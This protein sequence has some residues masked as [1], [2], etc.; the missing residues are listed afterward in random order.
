MSQKTGPFHLGRSGFF[1]ACGACR[2]RLADWRIRT[3]VLCP[4]LFEMQRLSLWSTCLDESLAVVGP[5]A[6]PARCPS[7]CQC[8]PSACRPIGPSILIHCR[9]LVALGGSLIPAVVVSLSSWAARQ[10]PPP[11]ACRPGRFRQ[12]GL[13]PVWIDELRRPFWSI[14]KTHTRSARSSCY[15]SRRHAGPAARCCGESPPPIR[16]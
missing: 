5:L 6:R 13:P 9:L 10:S 15:P 3:V 7:S 16:A 2:R 14:P 1:V 12:S 4:W 11:S 8:R